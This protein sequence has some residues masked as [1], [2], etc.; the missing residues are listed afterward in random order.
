MPYR[1]K[2]VKVYIRKAKHQSSK[3]T[4]PNA[5]IYSWNLVWTDETGNRCQRTIQGTRKDA[6][7]EAFAVSLKLQKILQL[8]PEE[9]ESRQKEATALEDAPLRFWEEK[10]KEGRS[11]DTLKEFKKS[12]QYFCEAN[13][14]DPL[15]R[16]AREKGTVGG[17]NP[18]HLRNFLAYLRSSS[19][20][21]DRNSYIT[22]HSQGKYLRHLKACLR[23]LYQN[24][25]VPKD[26]TRGVKGPALPSVNVTSLTPE[27]VQYVLEQTPL[28]PRGD[29]IYALILA[30]LYFACRATEILLPLLTWDRFHGRYV[31]RP[32]LKQKKAEVEWL[33]IPLIGSD[34]EEL[35]TILEQRLKDKKMWPAPFPYSY[36]QV[37]HLTEDYF[38]SI[39]IRCNLKT[40]RNSGATLRVL[41]GQSLSAVSS[42]LGHSST[43]VTSKYYTDKEQL[44]GDVAGSLD[45]T[46]RLKK[47]STTLS[48]EGGGRNE[49]STNFHHQS[50]QEKNPE[51]SGFL[52]E[53][54]QYRRPDLNRHGPSGPAD[55]KS[56]AS[57]NS[58]TPARGKRRRSD[59]NR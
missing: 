5:G 56:A 22:P 9:Y 43:L 58:A 41:T 23:W 24:D 18:K 27:Q 1:R 28:Y 7:T 6:E 21:R 31:E 48:A 13:R 44:R 20:G 35:R 47:I 14:D 33:T 42:L 39:G 25:Y 30:Y 40:L 54:F 49:P 38:K 3:K 17:L 2:A 26:P 55:F 15:F 29:E 59:S 51:E 57:T 46:S 8:G 4:N 53:D 11:K 36:S 37:R 32:N 52:V 10:E 16:R 19:F 34:G 50:R 12:W 45:I